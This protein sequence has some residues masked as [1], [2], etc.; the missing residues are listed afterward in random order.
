MACIDMFA[1]RKTYASMKQS[2]FST[3]AN[4]MKK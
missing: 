4:L 1:I 3:Q 2:L